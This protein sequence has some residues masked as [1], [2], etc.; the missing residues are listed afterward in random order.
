MG[1]SRKRLRHPKRALAQP[2]Q[3]QSAARVVD[4][5]TGIVTPGCGGVQYFHM[6]DEN[7]FD[8]GDEDMLEYDALD[9]V[10]KASDSIGGPHAGFDVVKAL[11]ADVGI[12]SLASP[13]VSVR[14][15]SLIWVLWIALPN[16]LQPR[17]SHNYRILV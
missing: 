3:L 9:S 10:G 13:P 4:E 6:D 1:C 7:A 8:D 14:L 2:R 17:L 5:K 15:A 16:F 12:W 11:L